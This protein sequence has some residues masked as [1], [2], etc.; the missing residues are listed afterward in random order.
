V[1]LALED[2]GKDEGSYNSQAT[3]P[4]DRMKHRSLASVRDTNLRMSLS[5]VT[6]ATISGGNI[7]SLAAD[8]CSDCGLFRQQNSRPSMELGSFLILRKM[9][10]C[11][12]LR[13]RCH[14]WCCMK[15]YLQNTTVL[16]GIT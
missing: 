9:L 16:Y 12:V 1:S 14:R 15:E 3:S 7:G 11:R 8:L 10:M 5:V 13:T 2:P 4:C 6:S